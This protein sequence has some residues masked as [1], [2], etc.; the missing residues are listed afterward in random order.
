MRLA[1]GTALTNA[2]LMRMRR[3]L[4]ALGLLTAAVT[5][6]IAAQPSGDLGWSTLGNNL[7]ASVDFP[8]GLF[9]K[10]ISTDDKQMVF[11]TSDGR[12]RFELFSIQ[13]RRGESPAEFVRRTA[14]RRERL[15]YKR[16]THNFI[17]ASTIQNGRVLYRRCNF[18]RVMIHCIDLRYPASEEHAWDATVTRI[19]LS[20]RP[21]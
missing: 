2:G 3:L 20:L 10:E 5:S 1:I 18:G 17:A 4:L 11:S 8:R 19:S 14:N 9:T 7:G 6:P 21:H 13:N 15:D 12:S 16:V